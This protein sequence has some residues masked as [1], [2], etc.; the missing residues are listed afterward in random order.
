MQWLRYAALEVGL[1][2]MAGGIN[3]RLEVMLAERGE[4]LFEMDT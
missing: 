1:R 3:Q 4:A 2:R